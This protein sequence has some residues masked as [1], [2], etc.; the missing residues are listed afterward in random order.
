MKWTTMATLTCSLINVALLF[1][2]PDPFTPPG[3]IQTYDRYTTNLTRPNMYIGLEQLNTTVSQAALP[4]SLPIFPHVFM[5]VSRSEPT[6]VFPYDGRSRLTFNGLV[7]PGE[8][9]VIL[10]S[11]VR[12]TPFT[13]KST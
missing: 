2:G 7:S 10:S 5:P 9:H 1:F 6:K 3:R 11:D 13:L 8:P 4:E 12:S